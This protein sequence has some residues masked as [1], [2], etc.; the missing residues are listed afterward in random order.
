MDQVH[1]PEVGVWVLGFAAFIIH[2]F[3]CLY[4]IIYIKL[5]YQ[6]LMFKIEQL[7]FKPEIP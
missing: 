1:H 6:S 4:F 5:S 3:G 2:L 7:N